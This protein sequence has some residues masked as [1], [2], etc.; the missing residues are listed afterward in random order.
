MSK[1]FT[2]I[3][4]LVVVIIIGIL[5]AI[6]LPQYKRVLVRVHNAEAISALRTIGRGIELYNLENGPLPDGYS[7]DFSILDVGIKPSRHWEYSFICFDEYKSCAIFADQKQQYREGVPHYE[8]LLDVDFGKMAPY[9]R[10]LTGQIVSR[11]TQ[12]DETSGNYTIRPAGE[13][14]CK[15]ALGK[16]KP[17]IG[18]ILE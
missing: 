2:L 4:L 16:M 12:G 3:E 8:L 13:A 14:I 9:I 10:V 15:G 5:S 1:A 18:C 6:A 11:T 7:Q 17:D